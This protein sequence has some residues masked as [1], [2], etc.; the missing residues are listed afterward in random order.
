M[1][2]MGPI[3]SL[4][5]VELTT[6]QEFIQENLQKGYICP[7]KS[8][9]GAPVLFDNKKDGSLRLCSNYRGLNKLTRKDQYPLL[10]ISDLLDQLCTTNR[11]TKIDLHGAYNLV[12]IQPG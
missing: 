10:L 7:S 3:Y 11:F 1:P 12:H 4:S 8:P 6:L 9:C 5:E 2:P